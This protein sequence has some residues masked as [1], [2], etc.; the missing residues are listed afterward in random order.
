V[1]FEAMLNVDAALLSAVRPHVLCFEIL[2]DDLAV[3]SDDALRARSKMTPGGRLAV[4]SLKHGRGP[5]ALRI[6]VLSPDG[7]VAG[8]RD[9]LPSI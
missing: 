5:I 3:Q 8:A 4:L 7:K 6:R 2:L 9:V 1:A